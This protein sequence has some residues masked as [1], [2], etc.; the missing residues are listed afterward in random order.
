MLSTT[1]VILVTLWSIFILYSTSVLFWL[2]EAGILA[3][4]QIV[5]T[6]ELVYH[7]DVQVRILTVGAEE[8]VQ[9]NGQFDTRRSH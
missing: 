4:N 2:F 9:S 8:V 3:R 6:D 7:E 1:S 5:S